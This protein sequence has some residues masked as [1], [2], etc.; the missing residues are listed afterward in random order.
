MQLKVRSYASCL[1][2]FCF[3]VG[4]GLSEYEK[5][6]DQQSQALKRYDD[7]SKS[8]ADPLEF[9]LIVDVKT[10]AA[11]RILP[12]E[13]YLRPPKGTAVKP[14]VVEEATS[15]NASLACF[16]GP[17]GFNVLVTDSRIAVETKDPKAVKLG[18]TPKEF[19]QYVRQGLAAF[20]EKEFKKRIDWSLADKTDK[21]SMA[22]SSSKG[23]ATNLVVEYQ[24]LTDDPDPG[25]K[26]PPADKTKSDYHDFRVYFYQT[27]TEQ[28][29]II[30]QVPA[31]KRMDGEVNKAVDYSIR[32][33]ALGANAM[34]KRQEIRQRKRQ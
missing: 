22:I 15:A 2:L 14:I 20:Y 34:T 30:Y 8:L 17:A 18:M 19:R 10:S 6:I 7:E 32:T 26:D 5:R 11:K 1:M 9:P 33:L 13:L 27:G 29:A 3:A 24:I 23:P 16:A 31:A 28:A 25:K 4:C 12:V 21:K